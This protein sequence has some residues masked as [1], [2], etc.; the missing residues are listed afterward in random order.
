[1]KKTEELLESLDEIKE[2][3]CKKHQN[4]CAECVC[5]CESCGYSICAIESVFSAIEEEMENEKSKI[6]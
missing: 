1:M 4:N 2:K 5:G 3:L 6:N